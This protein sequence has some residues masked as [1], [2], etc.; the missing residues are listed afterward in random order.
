MCENE[1]VVGKNQLST[2]L[3]GILPRTVSSGIWCEASY[4]L[5]IQIQVFGPMADSDPSKKM[6]P[7]PSSFITRIRNP[8]L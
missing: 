7:D 8:A 5:R 3:V 4:Q 2:F 1:K 6:G